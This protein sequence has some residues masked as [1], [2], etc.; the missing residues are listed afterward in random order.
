V[1]I[2]PPAARSS[3]LDQERM[4]NSYVKAGFLTLSLI[5]LS[6]C[7]P[8]VAK[9]A[10]ID[11]P[12]AVFVHSD[13]CAGKAGAPSLIYYP[14]NGIHISLN[15]HVL[16]IGVHVPVGTVVQ[17]N[18][19]AIRIEGMTDAG[20]YSAT[21]QLRAVPHSAIFPSGLRAFSGQADPYT[22]RN[23]FGP[24]AG[25]KE[26]DEVAWYQFVAMD[27]QD[28][29]LLVRMPQAITKGILHLPSLTIN[30]QMYESQSLSFTLETFVSIESVNC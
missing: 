19:T 11:V 28:P 5:A 27:S 25:E 12:G 9:Y 7:V 4:R 15:L 20:P 1:A 13:R 24:L 30:G 26:A 10:R 22:S 17:L 18:D 3:R 2:A 14:F 6:G 21:F 16:M 23:N 8:S 29:R